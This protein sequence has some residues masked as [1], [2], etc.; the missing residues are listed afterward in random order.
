LTPKKS[1]LGAKF[2]LLF[3]V[4]GALKVLK[5]LKALKHTNKETW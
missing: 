5:A 2:P 3:R 1:Y 4:S